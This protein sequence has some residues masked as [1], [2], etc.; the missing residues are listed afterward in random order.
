[1]SKERI[2]RKVFDIDFKRKTT[3]KEIEIKMRTKGFKR[4]HTKERKIKGR[5]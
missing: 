4:H 3:K 2:R 5:N 1:M